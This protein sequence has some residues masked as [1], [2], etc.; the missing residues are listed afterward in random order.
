M[1]MEKIIRQRLDR[2]AEKMSGGGVQT[3]IAHGIYGDWGLMVVVDD[4]GNPESYWFLETSCTWLRAE[5]VNEYN[6]YA[7]TGNGVIVATPE[8]VYE[9][10]LENLDSR[11]VRP[12]VK[13]QTLGEIG[14]RID[15]VAPSFYK[16]P[17]PRNMAAMGIKPR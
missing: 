13:I 6:T 16:V 2:I 8:E 9:Q 3:F 7:A 17:L 14:V 10:A 1:M 4:L 11:G 5:S 15:T 12:E